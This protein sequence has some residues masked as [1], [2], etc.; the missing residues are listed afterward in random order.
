MNTVIILALT[1]WG[2]QIAHALSGALN[3]PTLWSTEDEDGSTA[4]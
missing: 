4:A 1:V 2:V 3:E